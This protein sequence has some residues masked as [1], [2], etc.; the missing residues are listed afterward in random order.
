MRNFTVILN[1]IYIFHLFL[2]Q[3]FK[4]YNYFHSV[5]DVVHIKGTDQKIFLY[6]HFTKHITNVNFNF[7]V[8]ENKVLQKTKVHQPIQYL[9]EAPYQQ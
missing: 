2:V 5:R 1:R 6:Q 3:A 8:I 9:V 7:L 4:R